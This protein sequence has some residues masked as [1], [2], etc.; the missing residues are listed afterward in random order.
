MFWNW[1]SLRGETDF[2][3]RPQNRILVPLLGVLLNFYFQ[4]VSPSLFM[5]VPHGSSMCNSSVQST[6]ASVLVTE[7]RLANSV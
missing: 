2:K 7:L 3:P 6:S 1:Y 4:G 5:G